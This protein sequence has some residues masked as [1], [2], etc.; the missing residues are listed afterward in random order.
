LK[1]VDQFDK[2]RPA[3]VYQLTLLIS[4]FTN[5]NEK[6][7]NNWA[8]QSQHAYGFLCLWK[9]CPKTNES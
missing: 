7:G 5:M 6:N 3:E 4:I 2:L 8:L 1:T 9:L